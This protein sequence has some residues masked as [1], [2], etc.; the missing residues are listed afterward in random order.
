[1]CRRVTALLLGMLGCAALQAA[2]LTIPVSGQ[3]WQIS[4]DAPVPAMEN[5]LPNEQGLEYRC[6]DG[7]FSL[8]TVVEPPAAAGGDSV[9]CRDHVWA[10][11]RANPQIQQDSVK[12]WSA[13]ACE[14]LEYL[15]SDGGKGDKAAQANLIC[16]CAYRGKWIHLEASVIAAKD[17]DH[18]TLRQLAQSLACGPFP[19][20]KGG[21]HQFIFGDLGRLQIEIPAGWWV[22]NINTTKITGM[23][24]QWTVSLFAPSD[25]N[26]SWIM[27]FFHST[28]RYATQKDIRRAAE[29]A[30]QK[31]LLRSVEGAMN[32][33][34]IKLVKGVGCQAAYT[35][36]YRVGKP[37]EVGQPR[38]SASA[39]VAPLPDVLG[40]ISIMA[41]DVKDPYFQTA[42]KALDTLEWEQGKAE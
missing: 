29:N 5:L 31:A 19:E 8:V 28:A 20:W 6:S 2:P 33:Q 34:E 21:R 4:L 17:E 14:C 15:T 36:A 39:F 32:L 37:V 12:Q 26:K 27:T 9:A 13:P 3:G 30:Q 22:G 11:A 7:R 10:Q 18:M 23:P 25:P 40:T 42:I 41:D 38:V 35:D 24:E 16:C 1:M